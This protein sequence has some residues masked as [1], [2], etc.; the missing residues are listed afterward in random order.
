VVVFFPFSKFRAAPGVRILSIGSLHVD[1]AYQQLCSFVAISR[2]TGPGEILRQLILHCLALSPNA[3]ATKPELLRQ[4]KESFVVKVVPRELDEVLDEIMNDGVVTRK[5]GGVLSLDPAEAQN[6][7]A[8]VRAAQELES[9]VRQEWL[10]DTRMRFPTLSPTALW[11]AL[12]Q[13]LSAAFRRH[14]IQMKLFLDPKFNPPAEH[15][16]SLTA[17][18]LESCNDLFVE[19]DQAAATEAISDFLARA[20]EYTTRERYIEQLA[21]GAAN[22][23]AF[24]VPPETATVMRQKLDRLDLVL[25]TNFLFGLLDLHVH[26][27]VE[28]SRDLIAAVKKYKL[29]LALMYH[30]ETKAEL[31]I[32]ID[33]AVKN[34]QKTTWPPSAS[35]AARQARG[36][37]GIEHRYHELNASTPGGLPVNAFLARYRNVTALLAEYDVQ[38]ITSPAVDS[39]ALA[40]KYSA[41]LQRRGAD[42]AKATQQ[43]DVTLLATVQQR[44][45]AAGE[46]LD[47]RTWLLTCDFLLYLFDWEDAR[48]QDRMPCTVLPNVLW[49]ALR[50][51]FDTDPHF[52]D[53]FAA[54]F[55]IPEYRTFGSTATNAAAALLQTMATHG[56]LPEEVA[57]KVMMNN[58][59]ID[60]LRTVR[61]PAKFTADVEAAI[62]AGYAEL[63]EDR[64]LLAQRREEEERERE[65]QREDLLRANAQLEEGRGAVEKARAAFDAERA[66]LHDRETT[67]RANLNTATAEEQRAKRR[68]RIAGYFAAVFGAAT[69]LGGLEGIC[70]AVEWRWFLDHPARYSLDAL[71]TFAVFFGLASTFDAAFRTFF[72][73]GATAMTILAA[74]LA[75]LGGPR[76]QTLAVPPPDK[77]VRKAPAALDARTTTSSESTSTAGTMGTADTQPAPSPAPPKPVKPR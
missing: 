7:R 76:R 9:S 56:N 13:Y 69:M 41:F 35:R 55:A 40:A 12:Q 8:R 4:M 29:P 57:A 20:H 14:G 74:V 62:A 26:P 44:R 45:K 22:F 46:V 34:L 38:T 23:Y 5:R 60:Q 36:L 32:V 48:E 3:E 71:L 16:K 25:D 59:L 75:L 67:L 2:V 28:V 50:A 70:R 47:A 11:A 30:T 42:R 39:S 51:Y 18:L 49:Q 58:L 27:M 24:N 1:N 53:T 66:A 37:S 63:E 54:T 6:V 61:D 19:S 21:D 77:P 10:A 73:A 31:E 68:A 33:R 52:D 65:R 64:A 43:H 72:Q 15:T 17:L